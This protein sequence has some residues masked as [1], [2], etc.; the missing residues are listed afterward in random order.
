M[1]LYALKTI[2]A[3]KTVT[4]TSTAPVFGLALGALFLGERLSLR[5]AAGTAACLAGVWFVL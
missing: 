2:G 4:L 3:T 5:I 1:F